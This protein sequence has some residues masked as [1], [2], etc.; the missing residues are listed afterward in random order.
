MLK[1]ALD[2]PM[3]EVQVVALCSVLGAL[4]K[5]LWF[6]GGH[7]QKITCIIVMLVVVLAIVGC[8]A[9]ESFPLARAESPVLEASGAKDSSSKSAMPTVPSSNS[10]HRL[11]RCERSPAGWTQISS[12]QWKSDS[13]MTISIYAD[14]QSD[15]VSSAYFWKTDTKNASQ[16]H[17]ILN[18]ANPGEE[19][20]VT[21]YFRLQ[22]E[23]WRVN[24]LF[25]DRYLQN[26]CDTPLS[27]SPEP[28]PYQ[29]HYLYRPRS[30][31]EMDQI[32]VRAQGFVY[33]QL[34]EQDPE[35]K[36]ILISAEGPYLPIYEAQFRQNSHIFWLSAQD[37]APDLWYS[38]PKIKETLKLSNSQERLDSL[39]LIN[40]FLKCCSK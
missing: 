21:Q 6:S 40:N 33:E 11:F 28:S 23:A 27:C 38:D 8:N 29:Y 2:A 36:D 18:Q 31:W 17:T 32:L 22:N 1:S 12:N 25:Y 5:G 7:S 3:L 10:P 20:D 14:A 9:Q 19:I 24:D 37:Y 34:D 30:D 16:A 39:T 4:M 26:F 35:R 15:Q 13:G